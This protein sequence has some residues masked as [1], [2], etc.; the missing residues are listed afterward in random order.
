MRLKRIASAVAAGCFCIAASLAAQDVPRVSGETVEVSIVNLDVVVTDAKGHR[1]TGLTKN[2]FEILE[3]GKPQPISNF[4]EY[5]NG[6]EPAVEASRVGASANAVP[7][8]RRAL[9]V[10]IDALSLPPFKV[11]PVFSA[12]KSS[13]HSLVRPQDTVLIASWRRHLIIEQPFTSDLARIDA[14]ID[15]V[16]KLSVG[17]EDD[18]ATEIRR[19][20]AQLTQFLEDVAARTN[21]TFTPDSSDLTQTFDIEALA[22]IIKWEMKEKT[23]AMSALLSA[24]PPESRKAMILLSD[25]FSEYAGAESMYATTNSGPLPNEYRDKYNTHGMMQSVIDTAAA[26]G[27]TIYAMYPPGLNTQTYN[28]AEVSGV[29]SLGMQN[30]GAPNRT[31]QNEMAPLMAIAKATGGT[32]EWNSADVAKALPA[33][34]DDLESYYSLAYRVPPRH[35]NKRHHVV[36]RAKNRAYTARSAHEILE[37]SDATAMH[38]AVVATL[39]TDS[40]RQEIPIEV[41]RGKP[42]RKGKL[43][44][45]IPVKVTIPV[46]KLLTIPDGRAKKGAFTVYVASAHSVGA[47]GDVTKQTVPF[48]IP[49]DKAGVATFTYTFDLVTDFLTERVVIAVLD[50]VSKETG[51]VRIDMPVGQFAEAAK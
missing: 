36:V 33:I 30:F 40:L 31:L 11:E 49:P 46:S 2:D 45:M 5:R 7:A 8:P 26:R 47:V 4:A 20:Q 43:R 13:L 48:T 15:R 3:D 24:L 6:T 9:L 18:S 50:E 27:V 19:E 32:S 34:A 10:W 28:L 38:D 1:V 39:Y 25:R 16:E 12:L 42:Q 37:R 44:F 21:T 14:A 51:Y 23:K 29:P 35:D 17:R 22:E 41:Q